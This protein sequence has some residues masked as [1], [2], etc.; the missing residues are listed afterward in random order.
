MNDFEKY[1]GYQS[2]ETFLDFLN[3]EA[4]DLDALDLDFIILKAKE[5]GYIE[6]YELNNIDESDIIYLFAAELIVAF[7]SNKDAIKDLRPN[8]CNIKSFT[9]SK[10]A[11]LEVLH[12]LYDLQNG[13]ISGKERKLITLWKGQG[14]YNL[15]HNHIDRLIISLRSIHESDD[16]YS[17]D[18]SYI[19]S[20][21]DDVSKPSSSYLRT[22]KKTNISHRSFYFVSIL[23]TFCIV[24][25]MLFASL[26]KISVQTSR[27]YLNFTGL[28]A[29]AVVTQTSILDTKMDLERNEHLY[30]HEVTFITDSGR[31]VVAEFE[32][33]WHFKQAPSVGSQFWIVY[34]RDNPSEITLR[35]TYVNAYKLVFYLIISFVIIGFIVLF[36]KIFVVS[37]IKSRHIKDIISFVVLATVIF[38]VTY[39]FIFENRYVFYRF[40]GAR[41][42]STVQYDGDVLVKKLNG[43]PYNGLIKIKLNNRILIRSFRQGKLDGLSV[44]YD[45]NKIRQIGNYHNG[46]L[47][48]T[49][50]RYGKNGKPLEYATYVDGKK[51][52]FYREYD[53]NTGKIIYEGI[54]KEG[55]RDGAFRSFYRKGQIKRVVRYSRDI[56][57][58]PSREFYNNGQIHRILNYNYGII[59]G[60]FQSY[61]LDGSNVID[62]KIDMGKY[63]GKFVHNLAR[64]FDDE[65]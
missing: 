15:W 11:K 23:F 38:F 55:L 47:N 60:R 24:A 65:K 27:F 1:L 52:G 2:V 7:D 54:F 51:H 63:R 37:H 17:T 46:L 36:L 19:Q 42:F 50:I 22:Q 58:G 45:K 8:F 48:G 56:L 4:H 18:R 29:I 33:V 61:D 31:E 13:V 5:F 34:Q 59:D 53:E 20:V 35:S 30:R 21:I 14:L 39:I 64:P 28:D 40:V 10:N 9:T 62:I 6:T 49:F 43:R 3:V 32:H 26:E 12:A 16:Y 41:S 44:S 57:N 25:I